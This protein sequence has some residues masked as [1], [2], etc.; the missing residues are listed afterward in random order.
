MIAQFGQ[1]KMPFA[2]DMKRPGL[3]SLV[4]MNVDSLDGGGSSIDGTKVY[5]TRIGAGL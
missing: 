1:W 2:K 4:P 3:N 5:V